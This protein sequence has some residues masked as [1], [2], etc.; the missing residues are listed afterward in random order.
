MRQL[1]LALV[2]FSS[3]AYANE[4]DEKM[5]QDLYETGVR[6]YS[7]G[8]YQNALAAFSAAYDVAQVPGLLFNIGQCHRQLGNHELAIQYYERYMKEEPDVPEIAA[9]L[10]EERALLQAKGGPKKTAPPAKTTTT[11]TTTTPTTP[12][13]VIAI[14]APA[15]WE[16]PLVWGIAGGAFV[17]LVGGTI[18]LVAVTSSPAAVADGSLGNFDLRSA[19]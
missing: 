8:R 7:E 12:P 4:A 3:T 10:A 6:A 13:P 15:L 2:L 9:L 16:Q 18:A 19:Q 17:V 14:P 11:T 5:S 1:L